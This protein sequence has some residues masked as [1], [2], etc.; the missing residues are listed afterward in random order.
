[1]MH[2]FIVINVIL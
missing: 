2:L 1:M